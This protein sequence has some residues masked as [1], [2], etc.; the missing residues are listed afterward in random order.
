[1]RETKE[2]F[3][4][5]TGASKGLGKAITE[6]LASRK[7]NV[8]TVALEGE[9]LPEF[10]DE[11]KRKY[12]VKAHYFETNLAENDA[13]YQLA[14]WATTNFNIN[15]LINNA[16]IGGSA[17]FDQVSPAYI[18][19]ILR[20]NIRALSL[21][22]RLILP[23]LKNHK[24]A[25]ILNVA[26]MASFSPIAFKTVYPASK[27]FVYSFSM[28]LKEELKD[29]N[30]SVSVLHPGPIKTNPE[31]TKRIEKQG[32]FGKL[33]LISVEDLADIAISKL[34]R[35]RPLIVPGKINK[36]NRQLMRFFP[37]WIQLSL[38]SRIVRREVMEN[39]LNKQ[40]KPIQSVV[41]A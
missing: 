34:F 15:I 20:V 8:I 40:T 25:F 17:A 24:E 33:G 18:E 41:N 29:T 30:V 27:A 26:S 2:S 11:I 38:V 4:L 22:T 13:V 21:L 1:M 9:G 36:F 10:C 7:I 5:I 31:V 23:E 6:E 3:A 37:R 39:N 19:A 35:G 28:G 32:I 12:G 16:G 14:E